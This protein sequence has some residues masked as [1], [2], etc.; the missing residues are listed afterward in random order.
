M[1]AIV[2]DLEKLS[3]RSEKLGKTGSDLVQGII[4][5]LEIAYEAIQ[6]GEPCS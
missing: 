2:K 1:E 5:R 6:R 4:D 3:E